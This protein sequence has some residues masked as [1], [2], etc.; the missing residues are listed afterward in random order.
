MQTVMVQEEL[1]LFRGVGRSSTSISSSRSDGLMGMTVEWGL[2][3]FTVGWVDLSVGS[4][5]AEVRGL[6]QTQ[7]G[8]RT[9]Y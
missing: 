9:A 3:N 7:S 8:L 4:D 5:C 6:E 2:G 1:L